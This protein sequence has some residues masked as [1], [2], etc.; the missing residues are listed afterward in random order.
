MGKRYKENISGPGGLTLSNESLLQNHRLTR[1]KAPRWTLQ[2]R[3]K[4]RSSMNHGS[5]QGPHH[6]QPLQPWETQQEAAQRDLNPTS[7]TK[8]A[9]NT[10]YFKPSTQ[11]LWGGADSNSD[12][13]FSLC[14]PQSHMQ[15]LRSSQHTFVTVQHL[16]CENYLATPAR[17]LA[18]SHL[19]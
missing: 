4:S 2:P 14:L 18:F 19:Q 1:E 11:E 9:W 16:H 10:L 13:I 15:H 5:P 12:G 7:H 6:Q 3:P 8:H 17:N